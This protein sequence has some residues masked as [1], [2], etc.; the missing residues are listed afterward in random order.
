MGEKKV[1]RY[2]TDSFVG[3]ME[4]VMLMLSDKDKRFYAEAY[5]ALSVD[6]KKLY[7]CVLNLWLSED[8]NSEMMLHFAKG[9]SLLVEDLE[10]Q[11]KEENNK[12]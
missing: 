2:L 9:F 4:F 8:S 10:K 12:Q 1:P 5:E 6:K 7:S 11:L 3:N